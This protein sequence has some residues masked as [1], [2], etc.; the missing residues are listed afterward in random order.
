MAHDD[1]SFIREVN[2]ELRSDQ[3]KAVWRQYGK[4][5]IATAVLIVIGTAGYRVYD[6]WTLSQASASGDKFLAAMK[7]AEDPSTRDQAKAAFEALEKDGFGSY[8]DLA[9]MREASLIAEQ[10]DKKAAADA[11]AA[12][13]R[14]TSVPEAV[15]DAARL[16][17]G[18]LLIDDAPY[19]DVSA[20]VE[21]LA[22]PENPMRHS[23]REALGLSAYKN[24]D[25]A[26]AKQWYEAIAADGQTPGNV[27]NRTQIMLD[28]IASS[29]K[30]S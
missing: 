13:A 26:R 23:A 5:L 22:V 29:G 3:M 7:L 16:R 11:F 25:Y 28:L 17:A 4:L 1:D 6:Y 18:W 21:E 19:A 27:A 24:G 20:Q 9:R 30:V 8:P 14:D 15:R 2:E 10:G 12:I